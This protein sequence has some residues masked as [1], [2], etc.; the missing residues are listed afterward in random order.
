MTNTLQELDPSPFALEQAIN[1]AANIIRRD[2]LENLTSFTPVPPDSTV[3]DIDLSGCGKFYRISKLVHNKEDHFL[4]RLVT[5]ANVVYSVGGTLATLIRSDGTQILYELGLISKNHRMNTPQDQILR[6][7]AQDAFSGAIAGNF[8]GS[9]LRELSASELKDRQDTLLDSKI[10]S[11]S[12]VSGIVSLRNKASNGTAYYNTNTYVQG[13]ENLTNALKGKKYTILILADSI[14]SSQLRTIKS[15]YEELYTQLSPFALQQLNLNESTG[16]TFTHSQ[17]AGISKSITEGITR[18]QSYG[19]SRSDTLGETR[20]SSLSHGINLGLNLHTSTDGSGGGTGTGWHRNKTDSLSNTVSHNS[21][22]NWNDSNAQNHAYTNQETQQNGFSAAKAITAGKSLQVSIEN[23][24]IKELMEKANQYIT[25][26]NTCEGFGSFECCTYIL[27]EDETAGL[28]AASNYSALMR[29][30]ESYLQPSQLNCWKSDAENN[31]HSALRTIQ[32]YL[33]SFHH[34]VFYLSQ[35]DG[36]TVTPS[37]VL[38]GRELAVQMGFPQKSINGLTVMEMASFGRNPSSE[39]AQLNLGTL[40]YMGKSE[41][42]PVNLDPEALTAH[43]LIAGSTG[44]GKS[45]TV[46]TLLDKLCLS[47]DSRAHFLVIEP[48]KGEYK[49]I[50]GGHCHVYGTNIN[51]SELLTINPFSFPPDTHVLEHI[52]RLIEIF[53]AC[54]P[55]YAAMPAVLKDAVEKSY[56]KIGWNLQASTCYPYQFPTFF[57]LMETLPEVMNSSLYSADTKNDYS[58]AL[59]T[60]VRSLTNGLNGQIF[61]SKQE[62][63]EKDLF[64]NNVIIDLSRVGSSETKSLMMGILVLKLQEFRMSQENTNSHL[65]HITVL[66]EAHNLLRRHSMEQSQEGANL[67]GKA[68][69][70]LTNSIAEMRTYGEGFFIVDQSPA[71]LDEAVIRNTNTKIVLRLPDKEDRKLV[72]S[73]MA[74]NDEQIRELAK[75][76]QGVAAVYQNGWNEA[77]LCQFPKFTNERPLDYRKKDFLQPL[78]QYFSVVFGKG[79]IQKISDEDRNT[80]KNWIAST[81]YNSVTLRSL[82]DV[83]EGR[84]LSQRKQEIIA[85]NVFHGK[86]IARLMANE[87]L[88]NGLEKVNQYI[89]MTTGFADSHLLELIRNNILS[90]ISH[91]LPDG[92]LQQKCKLYT[93]EEVL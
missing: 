91:E 84:S 33:S 80:V 18:T 90:A 83:L 51:K 14:S 61:C 2:Y 23:R 21:T 93:N 22:T 47:P 52:D 64:E 86:R 12:A 76:P 69:E 63:S 37:S 11:I 41:G 73:A 6:K 3:Q 75:L 40:Q 79:N 62:L 38:N 32:D 39:N 29:G 71:L 87:S 54:W 44:T 59:I 30:E 46:Y 45:N 55:M 31:Q 77:V 57:D 27:S 28:A 89:K 5:V 53:N 65:S 13:I 50:L 72:G 92:E 7:A 66:E 4:D 15:G 49:K 68:I 24:L 58:G 17:M 20:S 85:Y 26:L 25:R 60:R 35:E 56:E 43:A 19:G 42:I 74:L 78:E 88:E 34:P 67:Q 48:A 82:Q 36:I 16:L 8:A 81:Q 9:D 1:N 10:Q 70:M